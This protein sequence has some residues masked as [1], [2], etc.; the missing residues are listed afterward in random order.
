MADNVSISIIHDTAINSLAA[1]AASISAKLDVAPPVMPDFNN[2]AYQQAMRLKALAD[3]LTTVNTAL[4]QN[5]SPEAE[6]GDNGIHT[7]A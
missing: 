6:G 4:S 3:W 1:M 2:A 5:P 7:E